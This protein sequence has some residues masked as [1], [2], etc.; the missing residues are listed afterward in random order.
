MRAVVY[1]RYGP[2]EVLR[3][4]SVERP[5]PQDDEVL[6]RIYATTVNRG[7]CSH[8]RGKPLVSRVI[9]WILRA[10]GLLRP[11]ERILGGEFAGVVEAVGAGATQF[12]LGD[13]V[14]GMNFYRAHAEYT[15]L[16]ENARVAR[17]PESASFEQAAA[18]PDGGMIALEWLKYAGLRRG[19]SIL[20]YGASGSIGTAAVQ[21]SKYCGAHVTAVS[22]TKN[23]D[24]VKTLG[25]DEVIDY[26]RED[27]TQNGKTYDVIFDAVGKHSF[28]R[29]RGSLK[30]GGAYLPTD[31]FVNLLLIV[32]TRWIGNK[33]VVARI[34]PHFS[35]ENLVLLRELIEA[36]K[37]RPVID[38][39][40]PLEQVVEAAR[41][42]DTEQK[43]GN[44]VLT[45]NGE[46]R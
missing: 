38:R 29:C 5:V 31:G 26:T 45:V 41:Y 30:P 21:L 15:C 4:E 35:K 25:A 11:K 16:R 39:T 14:F 7:D 20:I 43:V 12:E 32:L 40:Y 19:Q 27:F 3:V 10:G 1:D 9:R 42:V 22:N 8:R 44:V 13:R 6:V 18:V 24:L 46:P 33:R 36:G 23:L 2:P 34:P 17:M 37:Y 28:R